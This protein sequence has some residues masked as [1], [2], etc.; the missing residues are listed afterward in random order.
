MLTLLNIAAFAQEKQVEG[1]YQGYIDYKYVF[2]NENGD[3]IKFDA[4]RIS[5]R[6]EFELKDQTEVGTQFKITYQQALELDD[7]LNEVTLLTILKLEE[8]EE[9]QSEEESEIDD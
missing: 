7:N 2:L 4:A 8:K 6:N 1:T 3:E 9:E 5:V